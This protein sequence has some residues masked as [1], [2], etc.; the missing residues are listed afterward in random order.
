MHDPKGVW[1]HGRLEKKGRESSA[2]EWGREAC[3][4]NNVWA[5]NVLT[6]PLAIRQNLQ[7]F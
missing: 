6:R 3:G 1:A 2:E 4:D 7:F 5:F